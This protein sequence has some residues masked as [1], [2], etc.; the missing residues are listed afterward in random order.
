[1]HLCIC[2]LESQSNGNPLLS[3]YIYIYLHQRMGPQFRAFRQFC[4]PN[5]TGFGTDFFHV[6]NSVNNI[7]QNW[8]KYASSIRKAIL[9]HY[10]GWRPYGDV[11]HPDRSVAGSSPG[12]NDGRL[13][14]AEHDQEAPGRESSQPKPNRE[15]SALSRRHPG[16]KIATKDINNRDRR[17][18]DIGL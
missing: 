2:I 4:Q 16:L 6:V 18:I 9:D 7:T 10:S 15:I 3:L 14:A 5:S 13:L 8:A 1:M 17:W 12:T 11:T